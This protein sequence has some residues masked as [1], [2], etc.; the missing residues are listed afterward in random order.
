MIRIAVCDDEKDAAESEIKIVKAALQKKGYAY[1]TAE[2]TDSRNLLADIEDDRFFFDLILLDIEMPGISGMDLP[3]RIRRYLPDIR[4]IFV[5]SHT[6]YAIDAFE[7]SI[8]RYVPKSSLETR[9][10]SAVCDAAELIELEAGQEYIIHTAGRME[11][12]PLRSI[13]CIQ[14]DGKNAVITTA[15]G[16]IRIRKSLQQVYEELQAAEFIYTDRGCIVNLIHIM[17][18]EGD[19]VIL[20]SGARLPVSRSHI[21]E[22]RQS[23]AQFW[24][25]H[26]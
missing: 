26:I 24:G 13:S 4:I 10:A 25:A 15:S 2:Y 6:E 12:I 17:K 8:F 22:V 19:S 1:E 3:E 23:I 18:M 14:K 5:T 11:K 21:K 7:L 16:T 20:R 9:L